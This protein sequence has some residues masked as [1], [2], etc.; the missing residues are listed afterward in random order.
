MCSP[1]EAPAETPP[2]RWCP[3]DVGFVS[4]RGLLVP[5]SGESGASSYRRRQALASPRT[6][7]AYR[8]PFVR[9]STMYWLILSLPLPDYPRPTTSNKRRSS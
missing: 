2:W 6:E 4:L 7:K 9:L 3:C 8:V 1:H 5:T